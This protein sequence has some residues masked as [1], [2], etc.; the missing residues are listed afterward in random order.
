MFKSIPSFTSANSSCVPQPTPGHL[1]YVKK[2]LHQG[3]GDDIY[4]H[5]WAETESTSRPQGHKHLDLERKQRLETV[6]VT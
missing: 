5:P 4:P 2:G 6:R 3:R 1:D